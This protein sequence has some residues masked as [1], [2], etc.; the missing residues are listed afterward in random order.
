MQKEHKSPFEEIW[1][2]QEGQIMRMSAADAL[3]CQ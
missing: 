3:K 1:A 2:K